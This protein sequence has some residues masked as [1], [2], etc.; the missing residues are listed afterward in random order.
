[1]IIF[2]SPSLTYLI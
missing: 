2:K 1:M